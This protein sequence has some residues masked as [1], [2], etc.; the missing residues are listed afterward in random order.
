MIVASFL[1]K[2][3][4]V[5]WKLG[6]KYFAEKLLDYDATANVSSWQ[7]S[8]STGTDAQPYFRVFNPYLQAKKFDS[9]AEYIYK[10]LPEVKNIPASILFDEDK[11]F[12]QK[13]K[14]YSVPIVQHKEEAQKT[15]NM[16]KNIRKN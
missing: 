11:L 3:L 15:I 13:I 12:Q 4:R 14:N 9:Q 5:D 10:F 6:E 16:F 8:A 7:W 1:T 2:D